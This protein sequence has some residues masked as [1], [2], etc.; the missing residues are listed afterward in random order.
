[1][2]KGRLRWIFS[3][4]IS[5]LLIFEGVILSL[6]NFAS[7][8]TDAPAGIKPCLAGTVFVCKSCELSVSVGRT[9]KT[10][11]C[12]LLFLQLVICNNR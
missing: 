2:D 12:C 6:A 11:L 5:F 4:K 7:T 10:L 8:L 1:M 9:G 3:N